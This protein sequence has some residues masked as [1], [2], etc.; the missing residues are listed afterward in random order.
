M[1][2]SGLAG[3]LGFERSMVITDKDGSLA[4]SEMKLGD[5]CILVGS[6]WA[7]FVGSRTMGENS[8]S[9]HIQLK[10]GT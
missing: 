5:G 3:T 4:H 2:L 10:D 7:D 8:H 9:I 6:E 1:K